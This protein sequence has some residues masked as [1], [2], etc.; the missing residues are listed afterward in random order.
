MVERGWDHKIYP[1]AKIAIVVDAL[2]EEGVDRD[3]ALRGSEIFP[4]PNYIRRP[5][6][7]P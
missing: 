4:R 2:E 3:E 7:S 6:V 1:A 5:L